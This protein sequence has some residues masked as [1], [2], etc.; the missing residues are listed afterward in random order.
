MSKKLK[1]RN[2]KGLEK[3]YLP[4]LKLH[5]VNEIEQGKVSINEARRKYGVL[6]NTVILNWLKEYGDQSKIHF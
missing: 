4:S 1:N 6:D 3:E 2:V 5:I